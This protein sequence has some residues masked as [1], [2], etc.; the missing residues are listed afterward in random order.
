MLPP[1][2]STAF[3]LDPQLVAIQTEGDE[4]LI[5]DDESGLLSESQ[6]I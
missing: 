6:Q 5:E 3:H 1:P 4:M 2:L